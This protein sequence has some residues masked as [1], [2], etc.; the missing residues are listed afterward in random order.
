MKSKARYSLI[1]AGI[2]AFIIFTP[3]MYLFVRGKKYDF[4]NHRF[5]VTGTLAVNTDPKKVNIF[6]NGNLEGT[7]N[8]NIRLLTP[9]DYNIELKKDGYLSWVKRLNIR[10]QYVTYVNLNLPQITMF[11]SKPQKTA[12]SNGVTNFFAG[13]KRLLYLTNNQIFIADIDSPL[14]TKTINLPTGESN[15]EITASQDEDYFLL[16]NSTFSGIVDANNKTLNNI[17]DLVG[18]NIVNDGVILSDNNQV[19]QLQSG[20]VFKIDWKNHTK[21]PIPNL[22]KVL[23]IYPTGD[24]IYYIGSDNLNLGREN[25]YQAQLPNY[26]PLLLI[27]GLPTFNSAQIYLSKRNQLFILGDGSLYSLDDGVKKINDYVN[28]VQIDN[29]NKKMLY[30]TPNEINI[31]DLTNSSDYLVTR[32]SASI[33]NPIALSKL[34]WVFFQSDN[35]LQNIEI[36]NRSNQNN[37]TFSSLAD[38]SK[39]FVDLEAKNLFLLNSG[40]LTQ[41]IIR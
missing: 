25:L 16:K 24:N 9:S 1:A 37:Y 29:D 14:E 33:K 4:K 32:S 15:L 31:Y 17:S 40:K 22:S 30:A 28:F 5:V 10:E 3:F 34:G 7:S 19:F 18:P 11:F 6:L 27:T 20:M 12:I 26:N 2:V 39:Y 38:N 41:T 23:A 35:R 36:D 8:T 13:K 21:S